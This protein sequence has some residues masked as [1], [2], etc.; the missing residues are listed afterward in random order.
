MFQFVYIIYVDIY[1]VF[2]YYLFNS[3]NTLKKLV[4]YFDND[5]LDGIIKLLSENILFIFSKRVT[6]FIYLTNIL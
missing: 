5:L 4:K 6:R 1:Y 3:L 2:S